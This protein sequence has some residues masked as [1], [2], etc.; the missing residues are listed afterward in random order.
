MLALVGHRRRLRGANGEDRHLGHVQNRIELV[1]AQ[2][3]EVGD[4]EGS[5]RDVSHLQFAGVRA[6][7]DVLTSG[8]DAAQIQLVGAVDDRHHQPGI[9]LRRHAQMHPP[10][11]RDHTG[12]VVVT[13]VEHREV[14]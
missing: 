13:R 4:S 11:P 14:G 7:D 12:F 9:G 6:G 8:S 2:H 5:S 1:D 10:E 3:A